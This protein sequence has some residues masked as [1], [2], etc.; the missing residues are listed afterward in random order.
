MH[1]GEYPYYEPFLYLPPRSLKDYYEIIGEPLSLKALLKQVRGQQGRSE[2]TGVSHFKAWAAFEDQTSL[3]W[4]N[5]YHYNEDGSD[6]SLM[7]QE[8]EVMIPQTASPSPIVLT[9]FQDQFKELVQEAKQHVQEPPAPKIKLKVAQT[10]DAPAQPKK[11]TIH[12]GGKT[13]TAA[14][15]APATGQSGDGDASRN[16]TPLGRNPFGGS[17]V[18]PM[19]LSQLDK[20]RSVS[21]SGAASSPS[22]SVAGAVKPEDGARQSPA[23]PVQMNGMTTQQQFAPIMQPQ[24]TGLNGVV[25]Y[26]P[27]PPPPPPKLTAADILEAQK[28]RPQPISKFMWL[29]SLILT[30]M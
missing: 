29:L 4:K 9:L 19:N 15:P 25:P 21:V 24:G 10:T 20:A 1:S 26:Q 8:L 7:A 27:P 16:G 14:S 2:A 13:S 23:I 22:P 11:I 30:S 5:A 17:T 28:Y 3:I 18:P 12:V 6:I